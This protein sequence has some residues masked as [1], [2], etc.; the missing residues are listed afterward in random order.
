MVCMS[1]AAPGQLKEVLQSV[2]SNCLS[3]T[4]SICHHYMNWQTFCFFLLFFGI[5]MPGKHSLQ[6]GSE[7]QALI[8]RRDGIN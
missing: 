5:G 3:A 6:A 8:Q 1:H 4:I 7:S 2:L